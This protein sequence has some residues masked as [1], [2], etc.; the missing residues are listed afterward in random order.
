MIRALLCLL[1]AACAPLTY[2]EE[3]WIACRECDG[4]LIWL[5]IE[6]DHACF[7]SSDAYCPLPRKP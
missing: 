5:P 1:L 4:T 7:Q 3:F 2:E 6:R